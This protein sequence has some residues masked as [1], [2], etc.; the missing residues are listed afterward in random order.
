MNVIIFDTETAGV[1]TQTLLNVGYKIIDIDILHGSFKTLIAR[2]YLV[3]NVYQC[4]LFMLNDMFVGA[5]KYEKYKQLL[6]LKQIILR[7]PQQIFETMKND[8]AKYQVL[9]GYAFNCDF[10]TDKF[11]KTAQ[12]LCIANPLADTPVFDIWAYA[13]NYICKKP[14][15]IEWAKENEMFTKSEQ[16]IATNVETIVNY[17]EN[18]LDFVE[19]HTALDDVHHETDI[20]M[21]CVR[22]GCDITRRMTLHGRFIPS[23]KVFMQTIEI[24]GERKTFTYTKKSERNGVIKYS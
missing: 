21:E 5:E 19:S 7:N 18:R 10:D 1:N 11:E 20:L 2:D 8:I 24:N 14:Q 15:Y 4:E 12:Q 17:L 22:Q 13:L 3:R 16:Y 6:A 9:F 23:G